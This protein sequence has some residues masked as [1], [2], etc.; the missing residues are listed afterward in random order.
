MKTNLLTLAT[1]FLS[2]VSAHAAAP[3]NDSALKAMELKSY[4]KLIENQDLNLAT[5]ATTDPL[6]NGSAAGKSLWYKL[7]RTVNQPGASWSVTISNAS[8][9]GVACLFEMIDEGNPLTGIKQVGT[10]Q[11]FNA[12]QNMTL[13]AS[14]DYRSQLLMIAGTGK[15]NII[16]RLSDDN[17]A[18]DFPIN[19]QVVIGD[20]GTV[21][22]DNSFATVSVDEPGLNGQFVANTV[23]YAWTPSFSGIA[24]VDT[25]FSFRSGMPTND[26]TYL[27]EIH[28]TVIVV[29]EEPSPEALSPVGSDE[30]SGWN[31]NSRLAFTAVAGR[32]YYIAVSTA[33]MGLPGKFQLNYY[34]ANTAG[35]FYFNDSDLGRSTESRPSHPCTVFRRYAGTFTATLKFAT[36]ASGTAT[37]GTDFT[38]VNQTLSFGSPS[39]GL[40]SAWLAS[41]SVPLIDESNM[42][43]HIETVGV[44]INTPTGGATLGAV[45]SGS[46]LLV[47][48]E[49]P[50]TVT[51]N[52]F[53]LASRT[54]RV[55]E[56]D[57][58]ARNTILRTTHAGSSMELI[59]SQGEGSEAM[60]GFDFN[61]NAGFI[62]ADDESAEL[63]VSIL[64][65]S[66]L[67]ADKTFEVM[68]STSPP[69]SFDVIIEDNDPYLPVAGRMNARLAYNNSARSANC[70][71][72]IS[73]TGAITG[74][75][76]IVGQTL[77]FKSQLNTRGKAVIPLAP[78]GRPSVLLTLQATDADGGFDLTLFD[79]ATNNSSYT[80]SV[81]QNYAA[82]VNP[83][84]ELGRYTCTSVGTTPI[85]VVTAATVTVDVLGNAVIAG[86]A[87][88]GTAYTALGYVNGAA[89][90]TAIATMYA[91]QGCIAF[92]GYMPLSAGELGGLTVFINR[93]SRAGDATKMGAFVGQTSSTV[94]RYSP[95]ASGHRALDSW[96]SGSGKATLTGAGWLVMF[97]KNLS[98]STKNVITAPADAAKL[99]LTLT[100]STG[101][102]TGS[103]ILPGT[104]KVLPIFGA[105][106]DLPNSSGYGQGYFFNGLKG[107]KIVI[108]QP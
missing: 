57:G 5:A 56:N 68:L 32:K 103:V 44:E 106:I 65:D 43:A 3:L 74:K 9:S 77:P 86:R 38:A 66:V 75:L 10:P 35:E 22:G 33:A 87:F 8:V 102:F 61:L 49:N 80:N 73:R 13:T 99:K 82:V 51:A 17:A 29:F 100:P 101:I 81:L 105:L 95:P 84:P 30:D 89:K 40:D 46:F 4:Y 42:D 16:H 67:E 2:I 41:P 78:V 45:S 91:S 48:D 97:S 28:R 58:V 108:G 47:D 23:W 36:N 34:R 7:P 25:N 21:Q 72:T 6:L 39:G 83:C 104:T 69:I 70:F 76:S 26:Q 71:A 53:R 93:P 15:C 63:I 14:A 90:L 92:D 54:I 31:S 88:D 79:G 55:S 19:A 64:D 37:A 27:P 60:Q 11:A 59:M 96:N 107:G 20:R 85:D 1:M 62:G 98:V 18:N 24:T 94:C 50:G 52:G 12:A